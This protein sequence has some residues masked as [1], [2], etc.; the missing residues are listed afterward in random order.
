MRPR[1]CSM[2]RIPT[3]CH[4]AQNPDTPRTV[5]GILLAG[6]VLRRAQGHP[7]PTILSCDNIPE[8][9]HVT[10]QA[11]EGL[12]ALISVE[13]RDWVAAN[14]AFPNSMVDRITPATSD[15]KRAMVAEE[16]GIDDAAP[17]VCEPF[18]QWVMEDNFPL[19]RPALEKVGVQFVADILPF[20][21]MKLR[22]LNAGHAAIAYPAALLGFECV[23]E[24][25]ADPD[26]A[27]W[28]MQLMG[29]EV[30][31]VLDPIPG[32]DYQ[33][34][35]K[36]CVDPLFQ[37]GSARHHR[38]A[39]S[40]RI[41]PATK[42]HPADDRRCAGQGPVRRRSGAG[43]GVLVPLLRRRPISTIPARLRSKQAALDARHDP[44]AFLALTD[45]FGAMG[46]NEVFA[47][48]LRPADR[49]PV[50]QRHTVGSARLPEPEGRLT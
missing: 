26:I 13:L 46:Q 14:V 16:F 49:G 6:L 35:L 20:E 21:T 2:P 4:D 19:G 1:A 37:P 41:E 8:N 33:S 10:R 31:P 23:H 39:V 11:L 36:T 40:G 44:A 9:G 22:I 29:D 3:F 5:F 27:A 32:V 7:A 25:M 38:P 24:A 34:Y 50:G 43:S 42:V 45:V 12:A 18:S 17:V 28:L 15:G 48:V 47:R 30:I